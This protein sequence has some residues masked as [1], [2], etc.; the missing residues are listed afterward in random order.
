MA[1]DS[2]L[3]IFMVAKQYNDLRCIHPY[4]KMHCRD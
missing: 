4:G 2:N 1:Y 3:N